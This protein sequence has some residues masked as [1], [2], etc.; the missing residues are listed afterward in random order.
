MKP[1][2]ATHPSMIPKEPAAQ[3]LNNGILSPLSPASL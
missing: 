1:V 2:Y 3:R